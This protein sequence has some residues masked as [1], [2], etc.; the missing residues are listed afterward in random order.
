MKIEYIL[1]S[2][3]LLTMEDGMTNIAAE[4]TSLF[5]SLTKFI[6]LNWLNSKIGILKKVN[7]MIF[8]FIFQLQNG[9]I[10]FSF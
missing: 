6:S 7:A 4:Y 9:K 10:S 2:F 1:I 8:Y 3:Q 5:V